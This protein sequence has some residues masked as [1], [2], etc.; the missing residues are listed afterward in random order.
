[1]MSKRMGTIQSALFPAY[2][3]LYE[4]GKQ[5]VLYISNKHDTVSVFMEN[6]ICVQYVNTQV[7]LTG[8]TYTERAYPI[9]SWP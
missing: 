3:E 9:G 5:G 4:V 6:D 2:G 1:M 8:E 7:I